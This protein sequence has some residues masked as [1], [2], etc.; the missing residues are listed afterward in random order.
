MSVAPSTLV[1]RAIRNPYHAVLMSI[2]DC[3]NKLPDVIELTVCQ[4]FA[5]LKTV[6]CY[7]KTVTCSKMSS[8][9]HNGIEVC[10]YLF[11]KS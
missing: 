10:V 5:T 7:F 9:Q 6:L 4:C 11:S 3:K 2:F 8:I 1:F